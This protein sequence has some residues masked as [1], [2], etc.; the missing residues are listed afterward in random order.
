MGK[1]NLGKGEIIQLSPEENAKIEEMTEQ[2]EKDI[3]EL[4]EG[5]RVNFRWDK[6]HLA[7]VKKAAELI[8]VPYQIYIKDSL[9][10]RAIE[11]IE[12]IEKHLTT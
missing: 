1:L 9:F 5:L 12:K 8:G 3:K 7:V 10:R 2:A 11:D 6:E 4:K